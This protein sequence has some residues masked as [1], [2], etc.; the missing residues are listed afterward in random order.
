MK[1]LLVIAATALFAHSLSAAAAEATASAK[2][3]VKSAA[4]KLADKPNYSWTSTS[5]SEG[6]GQNLRLGPTEGKTEKG[7]FTFVT[8]TVND[9]DIE[10]AF[11]GDKGAIKREG[12]WQST[13]DLEGGDQA[14]IARRLKAFKAAAG[15]AQD[16]AGH[17]KE[18]KKGDDGVYSGDLTEEGVKDVFS[19]VGRRVVEPKDAKGSAKF[20]IKD[21]LVTKYEF[22]VQGKI[23][24]ND[25]EREINRTTTVEIKDVGTTKVSVPD[26][27][28]KKLS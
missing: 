8:F 11:K 10:M 21:G 12:E 24:V 4:K 6:T 2:A 15:E 5:K 22:Q 20:W 28:K 26:E 16:L 25:E 27:A 1:N 19:R 23:T 13:E 9:N 17:T 7:G 3:E 18:L 14:W